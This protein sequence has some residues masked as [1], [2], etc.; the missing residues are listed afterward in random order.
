MC[1]LDLAESDCGLDEDDEDED[2][3]DDGGGIAISGMSTTLAAY[4]T[5]YLRTTHPRCA[6]ATGQRLRRLRL[7]G[8]HLRRRHRGARPGRRPD[9][10]ANLAGRRRREVG[11][12]KGDGDRCRGDNVTPTCA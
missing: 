3:D 6:S 5:L 8:Q 10:R 11:R 4:N 9:R 12:G 2:E 1:E 7:G